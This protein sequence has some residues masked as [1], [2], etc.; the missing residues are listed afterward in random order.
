MYGNKS[1]EG[2]TLYLH[3]VVGNVSVYDVPQPAEYSH[4]FSIQGGETQSTW[5]RPR[6]DAG[7]SGR[8]RGG[9]RRA[10][11]AAERHTVLSYHLGITPTQ[12]VL[13]NLLQMSDTSC[14]HS[15]HLKLSF[16]ARSKDGHTHTHTLRPTSTHI[17]AAILT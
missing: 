11:W 1:T 2:E 10:F 3:G 15:V 9:C 16:A 14:T 7:K 6:G 12:N 13:R 17:T 5:L 4:V 8:G